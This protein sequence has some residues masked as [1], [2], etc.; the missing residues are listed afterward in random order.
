M[1][2]YMYMYVWGEVPFSAC[3]CG[4]PWGTPLQ[5]EINHSWAPVK[6][7]R[8]QTLRS[9]WPKVTSVLI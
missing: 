8:G 7:S 4:H 1:Y 6:P 2:M 3:P 9:R 5:L